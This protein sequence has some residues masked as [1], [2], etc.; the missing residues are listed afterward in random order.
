LIP[1]FGGNFD[2]SHVAMRGHGDDP[3]AAHKQAMLDATRDDRAA[4]LADQR[5]AKLADAARTMTT[6][7]ARMWAATSDSEA[8]KQ[9][10][11]EMWDECAETGDDAAIA[12]GA[13]ARAAVIRFIHDRAVV[14]APSEIEDLNRRRH[15]TGRFDPR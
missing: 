11:F 10:L 3:Y 9:A 2:L 5:R 12:G 8:R 13:D 7:L 1:V 15:S 14:F 6:N 4:V